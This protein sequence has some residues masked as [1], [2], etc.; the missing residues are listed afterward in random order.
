MVTKSDF[1][2][3][4]KG[5]FDKF[6][7]IAKDCIYIQRESAYTPGSGDVVKESKFYIRA[8]IEEA[9]IEYIANS[10]AEAGDKSVMILVDELPIIPELSDHIHVD[11]IE[12]SIKSFE[13]DPA[14]VVWDIIVKRT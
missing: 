5:I 10:K 12:W 13:T 7:D 4:V 6:N 11:N 14:N 9:S 2:I 1:K 8:I 3:A